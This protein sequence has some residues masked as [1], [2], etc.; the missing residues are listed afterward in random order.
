MIVVLP[1]MCRSFAHRLLSQRST[2]LNACRVERVDEPTTRAER[3]SATAARILEAAQQ[4]FGEHGVDG[5]TVRG[6]ARRAGVDPSLVLQHY[7]SKQGLFRL[8]VRPAPGLGPDEAAHHLAEVVDVRLRELPAATRALMRS[9]LTS[10]EAAEVMRDHLTE[11]IANLAAASDRHDA[12]LR[13]A[14]AVTSILGMTVARHFLDVPALEGVEPEQL[15][16]VLEPWFEEL[17]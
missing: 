16:S 12:E 4:E 2:S 6:I 11:R 14:L 13:A 3:R 8:A 17:I 5:T 7:G 9:M 1:V 10:P 15:E